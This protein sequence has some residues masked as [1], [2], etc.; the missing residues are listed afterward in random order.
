MHRRFVEHGQIGLDCILDAV[1]LEEA[2]GAFQML[3]D[4]SSHAFELP[5]RI[6]LPP[7]YPEAVGTGG[8]RCG[9]LT[10]RVH[11]NTPLQGDKTP[12]NRAMQYRVR[13][14]TFLQEHPG[15]SFFL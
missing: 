15:Y 5:L 2:L 12:R 14:A 1:L 8:V 13:L 6:L 10:T 4:I 9:V 3:A 11:Y 7:T